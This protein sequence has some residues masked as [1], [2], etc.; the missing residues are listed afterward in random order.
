MHSLHDRKR[1]TITQNSSHGDWKAQQRLYS[2]CC[3]LETFL[4][5]SVWRYWVWV[6]FFSIYQLA[7]IFSFFLQVFGHKNWSSNFVKSK[8]T[9][10]DRNTQKISQVS[11]QQFSPKSGNNRFVLQTSGTNFLD[12]V[13]IGVVWKKC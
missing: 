11:F 9:Y 5:S 2:F 3:H 8:G 10:Y 13:D 4:E 12:G 1:F 7:H 6:Y